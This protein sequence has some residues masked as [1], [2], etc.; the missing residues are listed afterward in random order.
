MFNG[1]KIILKYFYD[2]QKKMKK[3]NL[4]PYKKRIEEGT[5]E[6]CYRMHGMS[7]DHPWPLDTLVCLHQLWDML[8]AM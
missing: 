2:G 1:R 4:K 3:E 8:K 5:R 6:Q 7:K